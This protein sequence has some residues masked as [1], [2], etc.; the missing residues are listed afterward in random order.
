M[1][2]EIMNIDQVH[3]EVTLIIKDVNIDDFIGRLV[4]WC[5][6]YLLNYNVLYHFEY[7][8]KLWISID[9]TMYNLVLFIIRLVL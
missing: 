2:N 5:K 3:V 1:L 8:M 9:F 4:A 7:F 6:F